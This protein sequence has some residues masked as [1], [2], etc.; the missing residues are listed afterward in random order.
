MEKKRIP[1]GYEDL[2]ELM[3]EDLYYVDKTLLI[4]ELLKYRGKV[5][6]LTRPRR[7]GKTLNMSMLRRFFEDERMPQGEPVDNRYIFDGLSIFGCG[8]EYLK[9]Q[10]QYPVIKLTL[11]SAKQPDYELACLMLTRQIS[12]EFGRHRYVLSGDALTEAEKG[13]YCKIADQE[14]EKALYVDA[15][16]FL[17]ECLARFH[18]K[19]VIIL[20]DE[21]D[22]PLENAYVSGFY[23]QMAGF[24]RSLFETALKTNDSLEFA[25]VTGRLRIS[26][27]SIFTGLNNLEIHSVLSYR[28][29][30]CYGFTQGE[31]EKLLE[32]Y[33]ISGKMPEVKTWYDGYRIGGV[34]IYNP[35]SILNY[36]KE[37]DAEPEGFPKPYWSNKSSNSIVKELVEGADE[38]A[39][40]ELEVLM[41]GGTIEKP[42]HE[43][44][45]YED[46]L[47]SQDNLWN[48]LFF[49]GY[50]KEVSRRFEGRSM[51]VVMAAPNEEIMCIYQN[52]I[53]EWF[54]ARVQQTDFTS[55]YEAVCGQDTGRMEAFINQQL[56]YSISYYDETE[57]FYHGYLLGI[58]GGMQGYRIW[59]NREQGLGR[60]DILLRPHDPQK[61]AFIIE[62]K[63]V[64]KAAERSRACQEAL[65]QIRDR[66]YAAELIS[67]GYEKIMCYGISFWEK[68][69]MVQSE[70]QEDKSVK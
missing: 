41:A 9:H 55:F 34:E 48:F 16:Q 36:V 59:S 18:K 70:I 52:T 50:L 6:L 39:K 62:I 3:D 7:F 31:V 53:K 37:K 58:L 64:K 27:E 61:P 43:D 17:S 42:I 23:E 56:A 5:N 20:I 21:Y 40:G 28:Y 54:H 60:P 47:K 29:A 14:D 66:R 65:D 26:R 57:N 4:R 8:E 51:Y 49:T 38:A 32:Y 46:I 44:I 13:R 63:R 25:V 2:K 69:C 22:V 1:V 45:T 33:G 19:K 35:W 15:L 10:Q 12:A 30:D 24:V 11:K 67:D 68:V